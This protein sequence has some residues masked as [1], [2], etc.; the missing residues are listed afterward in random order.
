MVEAG[1]LALIGAGATSLRA[2]WEPS[3]RSEAIS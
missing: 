1:T 3:R 2:T